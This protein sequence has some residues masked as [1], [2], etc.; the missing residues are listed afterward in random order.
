VT[1]AFERSGTVSYKLA[2]IKRDGMGQGFSGT[3]D[4]V[5][6]GAMIVGRA[7]VIVTYD[8]LLGKRETVYALDEGGSRLTVTTTR[9]RLHLRGGTL[10][11]STVGPTARVYRRR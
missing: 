7:L 10:T 5:A 6:R 11:V 4:A 1:I 9:T 3:A 8:G 2:V